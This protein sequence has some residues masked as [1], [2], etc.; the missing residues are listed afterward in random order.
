MMY[1][2]YTAIA[3][4]AALQADRIISYGV[5]IWSMNRLQKRIEDRTKRE[6]MA[7]LESAMR[8]QPNSTSLP[9]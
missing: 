8:Q 5:A 2:I 7:L 4:F 9:N 6:A 3:V 1:T